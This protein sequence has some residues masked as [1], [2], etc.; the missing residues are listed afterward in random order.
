MRPE[1]KIILLSINK[2]SLKVHGKLSQVNFHSFEQTLG[3]LIGERMMVSCFTLSKQ[4]TLMALGENDGK[5]RIYRLPDG[6]VL[7][8]FRAKKSGRVS[9]L[10][11]SNDTMVLIEGN[12]K[13]GFVRLWNV[14]TGALLNQHV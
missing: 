11:F 3:S 4:R 2:L 10:A 13:E 12:A 7:K 5:I 14:N 8:S 9:K 6:A 1:M